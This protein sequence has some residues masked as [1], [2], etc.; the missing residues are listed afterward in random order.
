VELE[1]DRVVL[2]EILGARGNQGE[3]LVRSQTD[4]PG[5]LEHLKKASARLANGSDVPVEIS[6]GWQHRGHWVLKFVG[7]DSIDAADLFRG[8][9]LW[10]PFADRASLPEGEF[11]QSDLIGCQV[12]DK[13]TGERVGAVKDLWKQSGPILMEVQRGAREVLIPFASELCDVDLATSTIRVDL[14]E[15]LLDL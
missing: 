11:F 10:V 1:R 15:G 7:V 9:D 14:P 13:Q 2:A 3:V 8:A 12:L 5:R 4:V 6:E